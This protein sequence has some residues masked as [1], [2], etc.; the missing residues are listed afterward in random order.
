M[1]RFFINN[2]RFAAVI[3]IVL[4][5]ASLPA[6]FALPVAD[7]P[8][9]TPPQI[10]VT[11]DYPGASAAIIADTVAAPLEESINGVENMIY[12]SSKCDDTGHYELTVTFEIGTDR[13]IARV[14][15]QNKIQQAQSKL[16]KSVVDQGIDITTESGSILGILVFYSPNNT[17]DH[18][19]MADYVHA[20]V[21]NNLKR[22]PGVGNATVLGPDT[23]MRIWLDLDRLKSM[24]L[25]PDEVAAAIQTQNI[26]ATVG[27]VG[28]APGNKSVPLTFALQAQ[29]RLNEPGDFENIVVRSNQDGGL[30]KLKDLGKV[31]LGGDVY[32][33]EGRY[34]GSPSIGIML[35]RT[36][37]MNALDA[38][39]QVRTELDRMSKRFPPDL[40]GFVFVDMCDFVRASITEVIITL[41]LTFLLVALTCYVFLQDWRSTLIPVI[42][43]P[44][45]VLS[46]FLIFI[47]FGYSINILTLFGLVLSIGVVVDNSIV[48]VER[49]IFLMERDRSSPREA[50]MQ[51]MKDV[52]SAMMASTLVLLAMFVPLAFMAGVMGVIYRQFAVALSAAVVFSLVVALTL[53]PALCAIIMRVPKPK[54]MGPLAW[55]NTTLQACKSKYVKASIYVSRRYLLTALIFL[56]VVGCAYFLLHITPTTFLPEEDQGVLFLDVK[57]R[58]GANLEE[59][60][61]IMDG[62]TPQILKIPGVKS[63]Q[64]VE[65]VS[66]IGGRSENVCFTIIKLDD[67]DERSERSKQVGPIIGRIRQIAATVPGAEINV[68]APPP[69]Q[70]LGTAG[71][72]DFRLQALGDKD[73]Q[74]LQEV[75]SKILGVVNRDPMFLFAFSTYSA[76][77]PHLFIDV[78]RDKAQTLNVPVAAIFGTLQSYFGMRYVNDINR[79]S[80]AKKTYI[81]SDWNYR[82][83]IEDVKRLY[84]MSAGGSMV[85]L[86]SM[87]DMKV[88]L[89]ARSQ[90]RYNLYSS[91]EITA[92]VAPGFSSGQAMDRLEKIAEANMPEGY[93]FDWSGMS[94]QEKKTGNP[95]MLLL[96]ISLI[97][98]YLFLVAQYESWV[99]PVPIILSLG[100]TVL[101]ALIGLTMWGLPL[102]IYGQLGIIMLVGCA[103]KN[104]ILIVEFAK[105]HREM[106][107]SILESASIGANERF[108]AVLMT[109]CT[110]LL[111]VLPML[112]AT[113]AGAN[114]R[115]SLGVTIFFGMLLATTLGL[116]KIPALYVPIQ[117]LRE[118]VKGI[119]DSVR[120]HHRHEEPDED[121]QTHLNEPGEAPRLTSSTESGS[122]AQT[123]N[124][125]AI[126]GDKE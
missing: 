110:F 86:Q 52:T 51:A 21:K 81:A 90:N 114:S 111:G 66:L 85:P 49:V 18:V 15:V 16:P 20:Y 10:K 123:G 33:M 48:V 99:V 94:Y 69:I 74:K 95:I 2:P 24:N 112:F 7:Y 84:V 11:T 64:E 107:H 58:E 17:Y 92:M 13:N 29:G 105:M 73:P 36:P 4:V 67:W 89:S 30:V 88:T 55:F 120:L 9:V 126:T 59:N 35:T 46:T 109:A 44:V 47:S 32:S 79:G 116:V 60:K 50:T 72:L 106:G 14:N 100:V 1:V 63:L 57:M 8:E 103:S 118:R 102:S 82:K 76:D 40:K 104:A 97:F 101:G 53:C 25:T 87:V 78:D 5:I 119:R 41:G 113:G 77:T 70:G 42:A 28:A 125:S 26:Q 45:S 19:A 43:I 93:S 108:R 39:N 65:G 56:G 91:A 34:N 3:S 68:F 31:E 54:L 124:A 121:G 6:I 96:G 83:D 62:V 117:H 80:Q 75:L 12:M 98:G 27:S 38:M 61:R 23:S 115:I 122:A 22:I 71:G 37:G